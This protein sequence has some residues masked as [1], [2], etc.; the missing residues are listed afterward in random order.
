MLARVLSS[1][2]LGIDAYLVDVEVDISPGLPMYS[3]VGLPEAAVRE[4]K[5]RVKAAINN[6]GY[7]FPDDRITVNLAPA[8]VKK[9]GTGFD[10]PIAVGMLSAT[11][12]IP[13]SAMTDVLIMG[14]LSLDGR[15]KS[16]KGSLSMAIAAR[17]AGLKGIVVPAEN[18][19]EAAVVNDI[20]VYP[21]RTLHEVVD[22]LR[23]SAV[24]KPET[25]DVRAIFDGRDEEKANFSEVKGQEHV[26]RA[27]EVAAAGGHSVI[28]IGPPGSGKTM[29]A[30]R[31]PG[32]LPP[33]SF[34]EALET[35]K[36]FSIIGMLEK[37]QALITRR[38]FRS[39]HHTI[40][41]AG[42]IGGGHIPRPGEVS[43]ANHGVLFLDELSEFKKHV[44]EV[45][46]QPL[47]DSKVTIARASST[48]TYPSGFMLVA[49]MN[50]C[51]CGFFSDPK[52][53]CRCSFPQ[54]Q[55]YRSKISGPLLDRIDIHL[56][57]PAVP[58]KDLA[59][60]ALEETSEEIKKRVSAAR[61]IQSKRFAG[62]Q[63][64]YCNS[65]MANRHI[66]KNCKID[67]SSLALLEEAIDKLGLSARA[68]NRILKIAR[69]IADLEGENNIEAPHIAEAVQYRSLD[70]GRRQP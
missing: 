9:E 3:T 65:Q 45:L 12:V 32:I 38:P 41:D 17:E 30:K 24:I 2:V 7:H 68:Y 64:I 29:L 28:M 42:L 27:L 59:G 57:V 40:S 63:G 70:R 48:L 16:V 8:D 18:A 13:A 62:N 20:D 46:R 52:H 36:I 51:P 43:L 60:D 34:Q 50:P 19:S 67:D 37:G 33:L 66:K 15:T 58:Y 10:L 54:I 56:E 5:E 55:R 61:R 53:E 26:K 25:V 1:A 44:L 22:F 47:E 31:L 6:S 49:A 35:T 21:A 69:T 39:P 23:G 11:R 4:S 14:E